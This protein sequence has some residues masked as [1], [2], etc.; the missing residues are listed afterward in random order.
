MLKLR[1]HSRIHPDLKRLKTVIC[2]DTLMMQ[3]VSLISIQGDMQS[4]YLNSSLVVL[5]LRQT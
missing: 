1:Q 4:L 5:C 3:D 2:I